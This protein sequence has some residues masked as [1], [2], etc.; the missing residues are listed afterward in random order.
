MEEVLLKSGSRKRYLLLVQLSMT[1]SCSVALREKKK[2]ND[3][4]VGMRLGIVV[5]YC[6]PTTWESEDYRIENS[7]TYIGRPC[8][9][10]NLE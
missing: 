8:F 3:L 10:K 2:I 4:E 6:N 7:L 5:H 9:K 1:L